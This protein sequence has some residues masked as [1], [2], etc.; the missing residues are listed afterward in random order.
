M[1]SVGHQRVGSPPLGPKTIVT[2]ASTATPSRITTCWKPN[3]LKT[4]SAHIF[5]RTADTQLA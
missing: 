3:L 1:A 2:K 4:A 5:V